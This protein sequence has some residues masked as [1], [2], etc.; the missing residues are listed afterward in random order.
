MYDLCYAPVTTG[1]IKPMQIVPIHPRSKPSV[2]D[3]LTECNREGVFIWRGGNI[4][5]T[6]NEALVSNP[7][8][9]R[10]LRN[11][12]ERGR[13]WTFFPMAKDFFS[14][15][16]EDELSNVLDVLFSDSKENDFKRFLNFFATQANQRDIV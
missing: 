10:S 6:F 9:L 3:Y 12:I 15:V 1:E 13:N 8:L 11:K 7:K 5:D 4:E 14:K 16:T 2:E